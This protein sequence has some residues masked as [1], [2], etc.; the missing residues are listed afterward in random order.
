[1]VLLALGCG[2]L[3]LGYGLRFLGR[4]F[5]RFVC[6][7]LLV[8]LGRLCLGVTSSVEFRVCFLWVCWGCLIWVDLARWWV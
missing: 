1:M 5:E 2:W 8:S 7:V 4:G 3:R 6:G